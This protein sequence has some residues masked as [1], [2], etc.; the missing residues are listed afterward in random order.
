MISRK[1]S[2]TRTYVLTSP[3]YKCSSVLREI[4]RK[5]NWI[6]RVCPLSAAGRLCGEV[7]W[8]RR[9]SPR[10]ER[11]QQGEPTHRGIKP[12]PSDATEQPGR[13]DRSEG[14]CFHQTHLEDEHPHCRHVA[15]SVKGNWI[16]FNHE[17]TYSFILKFNL[18]RDRC[19][20]KTYAKR[21]SI[22]SLSWF[23]MPVPKVG[24][25]TKRKTQQQIR[26]RRYKHKFCSKYVQ[27]NADRII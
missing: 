9:E 14:R 13:C 11:L 5:S 16:L 4:C 24:F 2:L 1:V 6:P 19:A 12:L 25:D 21:S 23:T 3:S 22:F 18:L 10:S 17:K 26:K 15:S 20:A 8:V 7:R 27:E